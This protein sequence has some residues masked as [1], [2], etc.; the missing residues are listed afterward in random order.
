MEQN[1]WLWA[2]TL[3]LRW[4]HAA[5]GGGHSS[6]QGHRRGHGMRKS[7]WHCAE[8][9]RPEHQTQ[10]DLESLC[11]T[12]SQMRLG[13]CCQQPARA[14]YGFVQGPSFLRVMEAYKRRAPPGHPSQQQWAPAH[15]SSGQRA[16]NHL[17][18][19]ATST[20][21]DP[22]QS[23]RLHICALNQLQRKCFV[24]DVTVISLKTNSYLKS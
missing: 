24:I 22:C 3:P 21:E 18:R 11:T 13:T 4:G 16:V 6:G 23:S 20:T 7:G 12:T 5:A 19:P 10:E 15:T 2:V 17:Q 14:A 1:A 8:G 9:E